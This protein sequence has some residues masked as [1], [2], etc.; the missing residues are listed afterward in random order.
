MIGSRYRL[1]GRAPSQT[2]RSRRQAVGSRVRGSVEYHHAMLVRV[3]LALRG[4]GLALPRRS[5]LQ[6]TSKP[7]G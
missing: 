5:L 1:C 4:A 2:G 6:S 3:R 7:R